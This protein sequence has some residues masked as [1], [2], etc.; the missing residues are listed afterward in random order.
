MMTP[1]DQFLN[2]IEAFL[3]LTHMKATTFGKAAAKD[4]NFVRDLREG[5]EPKFSLVERVRHYMREYS[6]ESAA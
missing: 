2:D 4:P 5:R 3:A 6:K 1:K